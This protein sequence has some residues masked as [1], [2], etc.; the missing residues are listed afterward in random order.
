MASL[1]SLLLEHW[2][3]SWCSDDAINLHEPWQHGCPHMD[4]SCMLLA[5]FCKP[6]VR[7]GEEDSVGEDLI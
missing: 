1:S 2:W 7:S 5:H 4:D 6:S 3:H